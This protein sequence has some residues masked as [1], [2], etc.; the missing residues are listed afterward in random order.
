MH[1]CHIIV[2]TY[3]PTSEIISRFDDIGRV[4]PVIVIDNTPS[5]GDSLKEKYKYATNFVLNDN[6][7]IAYAQNV[8]IRHAVSE[9]ADCCLFLDQDSEVDSSFIQSMI[10]SFEQICFRD[11]KTAVL[12]PMVVEKDTGEVYKHSEVHG[13]FTKVQNV[14]SSGS[15]VTVEAFR[16]VGYME[17]ELFIDLVDHEWCWRAN[18]KGW[19]VYMTDKVK[20]LHK[21]GNRTVNIL[22]LPFIACAPIRYYYKTRNTLWL[23]RRDYVPASWKRK[24]GIRILLNM[25]FLPSI[26]TEHVGKCYKYLFRGLKDGFNF[27]VNS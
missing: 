2:V 23:C 9:G 11:S 8:G 22:G 1:N 21:V 27:S 4:Y 20:L 17:E 7:G 12:G 18:S 24:N 19:H 15:I 3:Y 14:I 16:E 13:D 26:V 5:Q 10:E 25:L 6:F